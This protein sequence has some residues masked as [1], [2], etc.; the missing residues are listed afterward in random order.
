MKD[1]MFSI[2]VA[3]LLIR[4]RRNYDAVYF[5]MQGLHL[6]ACLPVARL[7]GKTILMKVGGSGVLPL[8]LVHRPD[9]WSHWLRKWAAGIMILNEGMRAEAIAVRLPATS[10]CGCQIRSIQRLSTCRRRGAA[11]PAR[12]ARFTGGC[13]GHHIHGPPG[14]G[15]ITASADGSVWHG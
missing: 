9:G 4:E 8:A 13:L 7:L 15:E 10:W 2:S 12:R 6:A 14:T 3:W 5:L 11:P 1:V